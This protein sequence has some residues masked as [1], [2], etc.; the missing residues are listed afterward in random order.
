MSSLML[1][2]DVN[3][4]ILT[5]CCLSCVLVQAPQQAWCCCPS[6]SRCPALRP[7]PWRSTCPWCWGMG[8]Q[9]SRAPGR[10]PCPSVPAWEEGHEPGRKRKTSRLKASGTGKERQCVSHSSPHCRPLDSVLPPCW[11]S[12]HVSLRCWVNTLIQS[13]WWY[14]FRNSH[15]KS[16]NKK[17]V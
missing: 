8:H 3:L 4:M 12:W 17:W 1:M 14:L 16:K 9:V 11:L 7:P 15:N 2:F 6:S 10:S 13:F 5:S